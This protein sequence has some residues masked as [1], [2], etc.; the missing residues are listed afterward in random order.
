MKLQILLG[1]IFIIVI[2]ISCNSPQEMRTENI[3]TR[4]QKDSVILDKLPS[5]LV[6]LS[7]QNDS[8]VVF[9]PCEAS[10]PSFTIVRNKYTKL[11]YDLGQFAFEYT[12]I[13]AENNGANYTLVGET[14]GVGLNNKT[15]TDTFHLQ[16]NKPFYTLIYLNNGKQDTSILIEEADTVKYRIIYESC[17]SFFAQGKD[18]TSKK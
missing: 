12:L 15:G 10:N 1:I 16:F 13:G 18:T 9:Y 3:M 14:T 6:M 5:K 4:L 2:S 8:L 17:D 7:K 11:L